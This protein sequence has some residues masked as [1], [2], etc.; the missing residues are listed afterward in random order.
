MLYGLC[1]MGFTQL[2][3]MCITGSLPTWSGAIESFCAGED[4]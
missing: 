1:D 3:L 2:M 4:V